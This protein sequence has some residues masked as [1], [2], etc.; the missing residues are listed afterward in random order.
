[1]LRA[2][3]GLAD[4]GGIESLSMRKLGQA[5]GVEAMSLYN[6]VANKDD[7]LDGMV[8]LVWSEIELPSS[9]GDWRTAMRASAI[10][11]YDVLRRHPWACGLAMS[12][13]S[14][15]PAR[16]RYME[17]ILGGLRQ[18]GFTPGL[19]F[20]AYH[21]LDSHVIGFTLW[22]I[23]HSIPAGDDLADLAESFLREIAAEHPFIAEH[24]E[25]HLA[26][27]GRE[28]EGEFAFV[29]DLILDGLERARAA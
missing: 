24:V 13:P 14:I 9:G 28:G 12:R 6:H 25:Q 17:A 7:L 29:L 19:A 3:V 22:A 21:A 15:L 27:F 4:D 10:S 5:L 18:A 16:L 26:G 8:D 1:M 20:H 11:A 23:G 2:A